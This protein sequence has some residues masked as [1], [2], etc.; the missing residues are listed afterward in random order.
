MWFKMGE[1][2]H[3]LQV[4]Y[5]VSEVYEIDDR[6]LKYMYFLIL[7]FVKYPLV[8]VSSEKFVGK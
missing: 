1:C 3:A 6:D 5:S 8:S 4:S 2:S 7:S